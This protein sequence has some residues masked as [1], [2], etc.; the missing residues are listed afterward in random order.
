[1]DRFTAFA[2][3]QSLSLGDLTIES[4]ED[5][6]AIY[7]RLTLTA[8]QPSRDRLDQLIATLTQAR[9]GLEKAMA[10]GGDQGGGQAPGPLPSVPNPFA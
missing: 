3:P 6:L 9:E 10:S 5:Q 8:D 1:M 2:T 4:D 7:G